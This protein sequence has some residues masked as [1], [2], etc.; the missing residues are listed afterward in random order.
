MKDNDI[1]L[2]LKNMK[3]IFNMSH[4][5]LQPEENPEICQRCQTPIEFDFS[6]N[7]QISLEEVRRRRNCS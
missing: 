3:A 7:C 1:S 2:E 6:C 4:K 5:F